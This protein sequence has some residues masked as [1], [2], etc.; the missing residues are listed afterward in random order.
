MVACMIA[1]AC[2]ASPERFHSPAA[3]MPLDPTHLPAY[4]PMEK[5]AV[6][7]PVDRIPYLRTAVAGKRVLDLGAMD[8][9]AYQAKRGQGTWLHE[10]LSHAAAEVLGV[11][12][13]PEVPAD[14]LVT[15]ARSR[16]IRGDISA[17]AGIL[18]ETG[19]DPEVIV[20]GE[21]I[22]HLDNPLAFLRGFRA[23]PALHGR[24]LLLT[25]PNASALHNG[26]VGMLGRESTHHD[27]LCILSYK[28]LCTL[29]HRAGF[30]RWDIIPYYSRFTEMKARNPGVRGWL[31]SLGE[32]GIN[33]GEWLC[34]LLS[35]GYVVAIDI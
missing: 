28:T 4:T 24:R 11:D 1:T 14:G 22:E 9:T 18:A 25:T 23:L 17:L 20:A 15:G 12:A 19:F 3:N 21:L 27:H 35:F 33:A 16:I 8:E 2:N 13:S 5:L 26:L 10:E 31:V 6:P 29:C 30:T 34:P 32:S 7:R